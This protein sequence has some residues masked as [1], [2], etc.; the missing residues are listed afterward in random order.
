[1]I[2]RDLLYAV[3]PE[4]VET[5]ISN[6]ADDRVAVLDDGN[7]E[8]ACHAIP[9]EPRGGKTIDLVVGDRNGLADAIVSRTSLAFEAS[10]QHGERD[11]RSFAAGGLSAD[12]ID[13]HEQATVGIAVE[14]ILIDLSLEPGVGLLA[15]LIAVLLGI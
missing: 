5:R 12:T 7:G 10:A 4:L 15:A 9:L 8:H 11:F 13:D 6:V 1:V 3:V 2:A 14:P